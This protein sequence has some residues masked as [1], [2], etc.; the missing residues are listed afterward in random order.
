LFAALGQ[1]DLPFNQAPSLHVALAVILWA[2]YRSATNG[3]VRTA[4]AAWFALVA[5]S[6]LTTYQH[7]FIDIIMGAWAGTLTL[8]AFP[9]TRVA[10]PRLRLAALYLCGA[11]FGTAG[12]F[13]VRGFGW[14]LL[15]PGFA[16]SMV[17]AA[18]WTGNTA[19]FRTRLLVAPYTAAAWINSRLWT[20]GEAPQNHLAGQVWIGRAPLLGKSEGITSI[21]A[22]APE[23]QMRGDEAVAMLDLAPPTCQQLDDAVRAITRMAARGPT[24]VCCA[25]GYSRSA[26]A[27]AAWLIAEGYAGTAAEALKRV[28]Q[29]RPQVVLGREYVMR[30]DE[31]AGLRGE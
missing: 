13:T 22:L 25:L 1:F 19:W 8:A 23:L 6:P 28:R 7:H 5:I 24:L 2:R 27:S 21:V 26:I 16:L 14:L 12:A 20:R 11:I 9:E 29:A 18:Y 17:S 4:L 3:P 10:P 30:L 15:W 31:W